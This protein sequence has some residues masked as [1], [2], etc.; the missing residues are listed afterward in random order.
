MKKINKI[1]FLLTICIMLTGCLKRDTMEDIDIYTTIYPIEYIT[2]RLY[3]NNSTI[4]SIYPNGVD[5][6]NYPALSEKQIEDYS[7]ANLFIFNGLTNEKDY[8]VPF[9]KKNNN[10]KIIN[11]TLSMKTN[12]E[13]EELWLDPSNF[14]QM[15]Q[16]IK[17]G[18]NEYVSNYYIL[19]EIETNY[20]ELKLDVSKLDANLT[21]ISNNADE[22]VIVVTDDLFLFLE[23][24]GLDVISLDK[25]TLTNKALNDVK[26]LIKE[27]RISYVFAKKD[28]IVIEEI[29][30][31]IKNKD[32]EI[33]YLHTISNLT[34]EEINNGS[35]Y[36]SLMTENI[37]KLK[38]ELYN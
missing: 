28:E 29:N 35:N 17:I 16:N 4:Y 32:V 1:L 31:L 21:L 36:I 25:D 22:K 11:A 37:E 34:T 3:G 15:A 6:N 19:E 26:D 18:F 2:N 7:K 27:K 38:N 13:N 9:F 14:L 20:E 24:Y 5:P 33:S 8:V 12:Y 10:M 30:E 23:K